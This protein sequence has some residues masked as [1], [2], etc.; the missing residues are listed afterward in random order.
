[1]NILNTIC[2]SK[3]LEIARQKE[4]IPLSDMKNILSSQFRDKASFKQALTNSDSGIIAEFKRKS[5]SKGWI[6][7]EADVTTVVRSYEVSGA[8][9][10]SCLTDEPFFGGNFADFKKAREAIDRIPLLRK[11]FILDEYQLYQSKAIGSDVILLIAACLTAEEIAR[12]TSIAHD[13]DM[14]VLVEIHEESELSSIPPDADAIGINNRNL[15]T[16]VT[17]I[18]H[19]LELASRIPD[20]FL[21][22]SESGLSRPETVIQ[23]RQAGFKGFLMGE[24]FMKTTDPGEALKAFIKEL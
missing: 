14:E 13:L 9:A 2:H 11:D 3:R 19:T 24:N 1:M 6:H 8:T 18:R 10:V 7:P 16:F 23:L 21:K 17:D 15:K 20:K 12:F 4:A 22:I 5:P